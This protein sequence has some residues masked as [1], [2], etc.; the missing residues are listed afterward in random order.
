MS[1]DVP[2]AV[3]L[4]QFDGWDTPH[5]T[6]VPDQLFDDWLPHLSEA[7]LKVLLYIMRRT[8]GFKKDQDAISLRQMAEGI[9]TR[10]G[11]RLDHG[12]GI[13]Q[14]SVQRAVPMLLEKGLIQALPQRAPDGGYAATIYR[15]RLLGDDK[16]SLGGRDNLAVGGVVNLSV[17]G[18]DKFTTTRYSGSRDSNTRDSMS[19]LAPAP[20]SETG[21]ITVRLS[22]DPSNE[23]A[24]EASTVDDQPI[25]SAT[26]DLPGAGLAKGARMRSERADQEAAPRIPVPADYRPT[27]YLRDTWWPQQEQRSALPPGVIL[28]DLQVSAFILHWQGALDKE[29][30]AV[31]SSNWHEMFKGWMLKRIEYYFIDKQRRSEDRRTEERDRS[32]DPAKYTTGKYAAIFSRGKEEQ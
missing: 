19:A 17:G 29:G 26:A 4:P 22:N 15:L 11:K 30:N 9:T 23:R 31:V 32:L 1:D 2:V 3:P 13:T 24:V 20:K 18:R 27:R 14:R 6:P 12:A 16:L 10:N 7:E 8:Y 25:R 28:I 5:F 21:R